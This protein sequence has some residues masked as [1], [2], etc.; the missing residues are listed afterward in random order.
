MTINQIE[1]TISW[2]I[3]QR[4]NN[5]FAFTPRTTICKILD[6]LNPFEGYGANP[7]MADVTVA[8]NKLYGE[9]YTKVEIEP[10]KF[11]KAVI[12]GSAK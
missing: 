11:R 1:S 12:H 3:E 10:G 4:A 2:I 9:N 8:L 5:G 6:E 7:H